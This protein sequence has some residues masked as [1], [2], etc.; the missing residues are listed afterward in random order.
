MEIPAILKKHEDYLKGTE[1]KVNKISFERGQTLS[2]QS[3]CGGCPYLERIEDYP[4]GKNGKPMMFLAQVNLEEMPPMEDFPV[5]GLLQFYIE[6]DD[7]LGLD[8]SCRVLY[9]P[10]YQK[11]CS[12]VLAKNPYED[13]YA[14]YPPFGSEG[15]MHFTQSAMLIGTECAEFYDRFGGK[16]SNEEWDA[17]YELC[18][19]SGSHVGGYP[20]FVQQS[21]E[22]YD[23]GS[24]DILLLQLDIDDECG[25]MFGDAGN[26][27]FLISKEDLKNKNFDRV[28]YDWQCC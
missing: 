11:E 9:I 19:P 2:W 23:D 13:S 15:R 14:G 6:D 4:I 18:Y 20:L 27:V 5:H 22:Y 1:R 26:C 25:I 17:L 10:D 21:P 16:A 3:K 28:E 12:T 7:C 24:K 8:S